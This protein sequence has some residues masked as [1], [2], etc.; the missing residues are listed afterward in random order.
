MAIDSLT[1]FEQRTYLAI[2]TLLLA[3]AAITGTRFWLNVGCF[4]SAVFTFA[5]LMTLIVST[6]PRARESSSPRV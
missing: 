6:S 1:M 5:R 3:T 4:V 2:V